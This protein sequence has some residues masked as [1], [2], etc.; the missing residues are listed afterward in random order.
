MVALDAQTFLERGPGDA[1]YNIVFL[2]PPF[3][4]GL[5]KHCIELLEEKHWLA[6]D[7]LIYLEMEHHLQT[8]TLPKNWEYT[9]ERTAGQVS[10]RLARNS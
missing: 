3:G 4:K 9:H 5:I 7:A 2:D 10:Y 1:R 6:K 8:P